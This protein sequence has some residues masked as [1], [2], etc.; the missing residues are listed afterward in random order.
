[1]KNRITVALHRSGMDRTDIRYRIARILAFVLPVVIML[2]IFIIKG[3]FPFGDRSF[4]FSDMYHQYM[5]FFSEFM[6]KLKAGEG[7]SY[8]YQVGIGSNFLALYVYYLASPFHFLALLVPEKYLM[9]F[10]SYLVIVKVGLCGLSFFAYLRYHFKK[11]DPAM[12]FFSCF[13][14]LSGFLAAYNWNIMWLDCVILTPLIL[15]G[16]ERLVKQGKSGLYCITLALSIYTNYYISIMI[17]IFIVLYFA[18]LVCS[19]YREEK[20]KG[21]LGRFVLYSLLAGGMA[22]VLLV[23]EVCAISQTHFGKPDLPNT[24][25]TYFSVLDMLARHCMCVVTERGLDH[26][27]NIYCGVGVFLLLP[28]YVFQEKI[29]PRKRFA[30]LALVGFLLLSFSTNVLDFFWHGM[31]YPDSLPAR[32]SFLYIFLILVLCYEAY[33]HLD[34]VEPKKIIR[35]YVGAV[36]FLLGVEKFVD[37]DAFET[38]IV[39]LTLTFVTIYAVLLYVYRTRSSGMWKMVLAVITLT[40]VTAET[41]INTYNTSVGTTGRSAY[42]ENQDDYKALYKWTEEQEDGGD[43]YRMEKFTRKTKNDGTLAG[44]PTAS[45]FSSTLNSQ[46]MELYTRLGM[47][48]SKV[49]YGYDGATPFVSALLNVRYLFGESDKY[50]NSLF[51]YETKSG[52]VYLYRAESELPFGY[53]APTGFD[54]AEGYENNG[55]AQQN[56]MVEQLGI[57]NPLFVRQDGTMSGEHIVFTSKESGVYYGLLT[58][59]G[60]KKLEVVGGPLETETYNDLKKG[61]VLYLGNLEAGESITLENADEDDDTPEIS[62]EVYRLDEGVLQQT[63]EQL[64]KQSMTGVVYDSTHLSGEIS[65]EEAGR[66]IL[67]IPYEKGWTIKVNGEE[68]A[69]EQ[70]GEALIAFDLEPGDYTIEMHYIPRGKYAG[71]LISIVSILVF[72][73]LMKGTKLQGRKRRENLQQNQVEQREAEV[74]STDA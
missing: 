45:V 34:E 24:L 48:H 44:Y 4:L 49:Y 71:I 66:L 33:S 17:C 55:L 35:T 46:V 18:V 11:K 52:N 36:L 67:S 6:R 43:F 2:S 19:E 62:V 15:L 31:N 74:V 61:S 12:L 5:P 50:A 28:L 27:P 13:Y 39:A 20:Q 57:D 70:F 51:T 56:A 1:M 7:L 59:S 8:S 42:L 16:L 68:R 38:G 41:G 40:A 63:L 73:V 69:P 26:W 3:I 9:E 47:R 53:V 30:R 37:Q 23:P 72:A 65:L 21:Y 58:N 14:A 10:M 54:L 22:A 32:Q 60:T 64:S 25:N 29:P